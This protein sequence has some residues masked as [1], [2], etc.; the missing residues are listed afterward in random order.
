MKGEYL[1]YIV[2]VDEIKDTGLNLIFAPCG[3][4]KTT[5]AREVLKDLNPNPW[6]ADMLYLIDGSVG[7][8]QLLRSKGAICTENFW[9]GKEEW[10]LSGIKVMT[11]AGYALLHQKAPKYDAW[12]K[13]SLIICDELHNEIAWSK[14]QKEDNIHKYALDLIATRINLGGNIVVAMSAT[15]NKIRKEFGYCLNEITLNGEPRHYQNGTV[16]YYS[17]LSLLLDKIQ[18]QQRGVIYITQIEEILKYKALLDAKGIRTAALWS[19]SNADFPLDEQQLKIRQHIIEQREIPDYVDVLFVN[20]SFETSIS[21]GNDEDTKNPIDFM[22]VHTS[23]EDAQIQV[24]GRYRNDLNELYLFKKN[25][26][27]IIEL[28]RKWLFTKLSKK[29]RDELCAELG[30]TDKNG[31]LLK[32]TSIKSKLEKSGYIIEDVRT[33]KER[34]VTIHEL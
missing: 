24:R 17:N 2:D 23:E 7:K 34:F 25:A 1:K 28:P 4:G 18:P 20:K 11:Y 30:F 9:T 26:D 12:E 6:G 29:D 32:W 19:M 33:S 22:I 31:R 14:W 8:E 5:F 21:M 15:P 10:S 3:S 27:E 13:R 16:S